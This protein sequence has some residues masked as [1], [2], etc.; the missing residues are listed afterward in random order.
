[1]YC[2]GEKVTSFDYREQEEMDRFIAKLS[3]QPKISNDN[4]IS[5]RFKEEKMYSRCEVEELFEKY[6]DADMPQLYPWIK[7]NLK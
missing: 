7:E 2:N 1:V 4:Q 6:V 5:I 3:K